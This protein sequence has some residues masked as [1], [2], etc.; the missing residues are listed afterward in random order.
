MKKY[1]TILSI[2]TVIILIHAVVLFSCMY[3]ER[4]NV[5]EVEEPRLAPP[6]AAE[7]QMPVIDP[8][9]VGQA[10]PAPGSVP[11]SPLPEE[12]RD[13]ERT[14]DHPRKRQRIL[15]HFTDLGCSSDV[16]GRK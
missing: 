11:L 10:A 7:P 3:S 8:V 4:K 12:P 14:R 16:S 15:C 13:P 2:L 1:G 6:V 5:R 9:P